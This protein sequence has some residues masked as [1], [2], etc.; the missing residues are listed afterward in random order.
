MALKVQTLLYTQ[1]VDTHTHT[2]TKTEN[3]IKVFLFTPSW[4]FLYM[5]Q[6][7]PEPLQYP[8]WHP[9]ITK[10]L[11]ANGTHTHTACGIQ[12]IYPHIAHV[13]HDPPWYRK[14]YT[15]TASCTCTIKTVHTDVNPM[16]SVGI[17]THIHIHT[18]TAEGSGFH[19]KGVGGCPSI[20]GRHSRA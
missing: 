10:H 15:L 1:Q 16:H 4:V 9:G 18:H 19:Y 11:L 8:G 12:P 20:W 13:H 5:P 17:F 7:S 3:T 2:H 14:K 6:T